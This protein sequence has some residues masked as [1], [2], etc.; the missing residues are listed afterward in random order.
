MG[1]KAEP[2]SRKATASGSHTL[3]D[4]PEPPGFKY[5]TTTAQASMQFCPNF[6]AQTFK[7]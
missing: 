6:Q 1:Q 5:C 2:Q 4:T 3:A 7:L